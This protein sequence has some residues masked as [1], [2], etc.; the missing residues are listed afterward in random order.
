[1]FVCMQLSKNEERSIW[2]NILHNTFFLQRKERGFV[3]GHYHHD[4]HKLGL[5]IRSEK[6]AAP[7]SPEAMLMQANLS[8]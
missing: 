8:F 3:Y 2:G 4:H 1:M 6:A 7:S 5:V